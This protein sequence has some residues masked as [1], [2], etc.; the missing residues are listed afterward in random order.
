MNALFVALLFSTAS[1]TFSDAST[2]FSPS[3]VMAESDH[4]QVI[5]QAI[6]TITEGLADCD[7]M[8]L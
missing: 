3:P 2:L 7:G 8:K 1:P 5:D 4:I 6:I